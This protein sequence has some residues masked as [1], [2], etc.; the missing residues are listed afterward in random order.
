[1]T[2]T[3][4]ALVAP[5]LPPHPWLGRPAGDRCI[6]EGAGALSHERA[7]PKDIDGFGSDGRLILRRLPPPSAESRKASDV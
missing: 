2:R 1:M 4:S 7:I 5:R 6:R 3:I